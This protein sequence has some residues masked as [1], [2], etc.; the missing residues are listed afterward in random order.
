MGNWQVSYLMKM[1][2]SNNPSACLQ[3]NK[4]LTYK[5]RK[6]LF[7][8]KDCVAKYYTTKVDGVYSVGKKWARNCPTCGNT[9][10]YTR[11]ENAR[12]IH[13]RNTECKKCAKSHIKDSTIEKMRQTQLERFARIRKEKNYLPL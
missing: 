6:R 3:C 5:Q 8:S 2:Y 7:C 12:M 10:L 1:D 9:I 13:L 11:Y 4:N